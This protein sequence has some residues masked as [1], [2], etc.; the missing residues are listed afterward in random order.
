MP[1]PELP[2]RHLVPERSTALLLLPEQLAVIDMFGFSS[3]VC[4]CFCASRVAV[5]AEGRSELCS[6]SFTACGL[7]AEPGQ[8]PAAHLGL[9]RVGL[10]TAPPCLCP[11]KEPGLEP[12]KSSQRSQALSC[13]DRRGSAVKA[14]GKT[15]FPV[16]LLPL[17]TH[18]CP[19][20]YIPLPALQ[21]G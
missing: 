19:A 15:E 4:I 7:N 21:P 14:R 8:P 13:T 2:A 11:K 20:F 16:C 10:V 17:G 1:A 5:R 6:V 9:C 3:I 12:K 18:P